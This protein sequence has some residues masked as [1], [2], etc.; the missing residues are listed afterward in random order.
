LK[1]I[2]KR[3]MKKTKKKA[4]QNENDFHHKRERKEMRS[5]R[6]RERLS[7]WMA[8]VM[9]EETHKKHTQ[10]ERL[11]VYE[12]LSLSLSL[13][14][15]TTKCVLGIEIVYSISCKPECS[16]QIILALF[17]ISRYSVALL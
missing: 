13:S 5:R 1:A 14:V 17:I 7:G 16:R 9:I 4:K 8:S 11:H 3:E 15:Y 10:R 2:E 6:G 12:C